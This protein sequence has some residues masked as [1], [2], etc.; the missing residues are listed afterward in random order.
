MHHRGDTLHAIIGLCLIC[1]AARGGETP[2]S[3][4]TVRTKETIVTATR[5]EADVFDVPYTATVVEEW[6]IRNR[7][8]AQ[9]LPQALQEDPSIMVQRTARGQGSPFLRGF[10]GFRTLLL[11]DGIRVN[12]SV[13]RD[14]PNQYWMTVDPF[15]VQRLETVRG[16]SSVLYG[17][18]AVG[19]TVNAISQGRTEFPGGFNWSRRILYRYGSAD[20]SHIGRVEVDGNWDRHLGFHFGFT[21]SDFDELYAGHGVRKQEKTDYEERSWD[22]KIEYLLG[23]DNKLIL[24]H[25]AYH[26]D[27]AW[28][29]H[30]TI[31]GISWHGTDIG[32]ELER[33][34]DLDRELTYLR[35]DAQNLDTWVDAATLTISYQ[36]L[37]EEQYRIKAD[38]SSDLQGF[39][40][41]T[42][43]LAGQLQSPTPIGLFTYGV[44]Y[45]RDSV[46]SFARKW[47]PNGIFDSEKVQGPVGDDATYD[48]LGIYVQDEFTPVERLDVTL[49]TRYTYAAADAKEV[50][51]PVTGDVMRVKDHWHNLSGS[52]RAVY[53]VTE[54]W[55]IFG[56]LS[57]GFRAPNLSD[58]TRYDS[59]RSDEIETPSPDLD[60]E[61]YVAAELGVKADTEHWRGSLSLFHTWIRD[62]IIRYPTGRTV[63]DASEV[64]KASVGDGH[65]NGFELTGE[66]FVT[67]KWSF[68][69]GMSWQRGEVDT[70]PTSEKEK[71]REHMSRIAPVTGL[72]GTRWREPQDRF[73]CEFVGRMADSQNRLS[74]RDEGDT[75]RIPPG[76]TPGYGVLDVRVGCTL[77]EDFRLTAAVENVFNKAYRIHGSGLNEPGRNF[78]LTADWE[79]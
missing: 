14:G 19:G 25:N 29:T 34:T 68:F 38:E 18:D 56:G 17:S 39:D 52:A 22:G 15:M 13:F 59:A 47:K 5:H 1:A 3:V 54:T 78:L 64:Q 69:G 67:P 7:M 45:Y 55:N 50:E 11:I 65:V 32:D 6:D 43:G 33:S 16:P 28:R 10:T 42:L 31:Y 9:N 27:D 21:A 70:Y 44:E 4:A 40:V 74:P 57:Q 36:T 63:D 72:V 26:Q 41:R 77:W 46:S 73:W 48:L 20:S 35:W 12:N 60:P 49:G 37:E 71:E 53:H 66:V 79:F 51:D 24:A 30:K 62:M 76:G 58:L 8:M 2:A 23:P 61:K 75:Q